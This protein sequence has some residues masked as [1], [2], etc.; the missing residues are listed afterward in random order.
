[1]QVLSLN[2]IVRV[3]L[4]QALRGL[5]NI[6]TSALGLVTHEVPIPDDYGDFGIYLDPSG[7]ADDF[8]INSVTYRLSVQTFT[9]SPNML[10]G[11]GY[12]VIIPRKQSASATP[13]TILGSGSVNLT[14]LT[15][16]DYEINV[17][18]DGG[19]AVDVEIGEIDLTSV[20]T[21][22]A[23]LN[24]YEAEIAGIEFEVSGELSSAIITIKS[25][26]DG[27]SSEL[28]IGTSVS[29][30]T[31]IA[32]ALKL[33][34]S[35][36]GTASGLESVKDCILRTS[37]SVAYFG[38]IYSE[39]LTDA[40]LEG[41]APVVQSLDKIQF[42]GNNDF[43]KVAGVFTDIKDSGLVNT[44]CLHYSVSSAKALDFTAGYAGRALSTDF[45]GTATAQTMHLK[46]IVGLV[47]D[48]N[49]TQTRLQACLNAG[50]DIYANFGIPKV[51]TSGVNQFFDQV[52]NRLA[53][54]LR[55]RIAGFNFLATTQTKIPQTEE[56]LSALKSAYQIVCDQF[57]TAG[58]FAPGTWNGST[59]FGKPQDHLR[60]I[61]DFG[62]YIYSIPIALQAQI[63][64]EARVAPL[65]Q[66]AAKESGAI[67][68]SS[69]TVLVEA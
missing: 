41:V 14:A 31:N 44:R 27:A 53:F 39:I 21:A 15:G 17:A 23:S 46:D 30:G 7:V 35:A 50:V 48:P 69:V 49:L 58:V 12:L 24:S 66:I 32:N 57:V 65:I 9:Q 1:M 45:A 68:S 63:D 47:A 55:L 64:R 42:V 43:T 6:N 3:S 51:F 22:Q 62:Y 29:T 28:E 34:G 2:N 25:A 60:N 10:T 40:I 20:Q 5:T 37:S 18:V 13:A 16:E 11:N 26:T 36:I 54:K 67:H 4:L 33:S 19:S 52:Y 61:S 56:G 8:G 38:I 59:T